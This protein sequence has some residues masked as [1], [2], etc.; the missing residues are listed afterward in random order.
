MG[1]E[2]LAEERA[3]A[4]HRAIDELI[5]NDD[6]ERLELF[7]QA[8]DGA[9]RQDEFHAELLQAED[10]GAE[11]ELARQQPVPGAVPRQERHSLAAQRADDVG[12]RRVAK[13][14]GQ[15]HFGPVRH[16]G[17]VVQAAATNDPDAN[18]FHTSFC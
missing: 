10:V 12:A 6:V 9:R 7:F 1:G 11:V 14:R 8:A 2:A 16:L 17:H 5:R 18:V 3:D 4:A 13:R 15:G